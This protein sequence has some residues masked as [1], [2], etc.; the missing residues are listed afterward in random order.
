M[1]KDT[2]DKLKI[3]KLEEY[4]GYVNDEYGE[5]C[6]KLCALARDC[7]MMEQGLIKALREEIEARLSEFKSE[8]RLV[9]KEE[10]ITRKYTELE[11]INE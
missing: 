7:Y 9:K 6:Y 1:S 3:A 10:T 4:A 5:Y 11:W 8:T 2:I